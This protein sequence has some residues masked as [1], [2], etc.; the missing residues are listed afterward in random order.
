MTIS[1]M[2]SKSIEAAKSLEVLVLS[3]V[4]PSRDPRIVDK[5]IRTLAGHGHA[6]TW[7]RPGPVE[8]ASPAP[9]DVEEISF[10]A[11]QGRLR[12]IFTSW[13]A[14]RKIINKTRPDI[15]HLHD[16]ELLLVGL[17]PR[18]PGC[19]Y[20][21]DAHE[22]IGLQVLAKPWIPGFLRR[23]V[24]FASNALARLLMRRFDAVIT[25]T[26]DINERL[27]SLPVQCVT[28]RNFPRLEQF[29]VA[30]AVPEDLVYVGRISR[31]RGLEEMLS[32]AQATGRRL[33]L[34]GRV[35]PACQAM[36]D[37]ATSDGVCDYHG[38][39][40]REGVAKLLRGGG[41]GLCLLHDKVNYRRALPTKLF[42][43]MASGLPVIVTAFP[44]WRD[45]VQAAG[46]GLAVDLKD[47]TQGW[48]EVTRW[49]ERGALREQGAAG[50][51]HVET[52]ASWE[53]E[54]SA[55]LALYDELAEGAGGGSG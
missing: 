23:P 37:R 24:A 54:A 11:R 38:E 32:L 49:L 13:L 28:L 53:Q 19:R 30:T 2:I 5:E 27:S 50:R 41:I 35:D 31:D 10:P 43:Y 8:T 36:L 4:H 16:P 46:A 34:A 9:V 6:V 45:I 29:S 14:A 22:D 3:S 18:L 12:R 25:A 26:T 55:L 33:Q 7:C 15:V 17:L 42:E 48:P 47:G 40:D 39:L 52:Q 44:L 20:I 1:K 21:Y 51:R